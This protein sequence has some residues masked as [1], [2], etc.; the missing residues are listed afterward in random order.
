[1]GERPFVGGPGGVYICSDCILATVTAADAGSAVV[2]GLRLTRVV[3]A[4]PGGQAPPEHCDF[5]SKP[6][7]AVGWIVAGAAA[8]ICDECTDLCVEILAEQ[9]TAG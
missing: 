1:M 3:P 7:M 9:E 5:C 2:A 4:P 6:S 8:V